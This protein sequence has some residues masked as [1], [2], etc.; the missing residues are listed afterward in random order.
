LA[1][2]DYSDYAFSIR[3]NCSD[4]QSEI[5]CVNNVGVG[6]KEQLIFNFEGAVTY[7]IIVEGASVLDTG[8]YI[9]FIEKYYP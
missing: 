6:Q 2:Q 4:W 5:T 9:L 1:P 3:T 7:Y 8:D